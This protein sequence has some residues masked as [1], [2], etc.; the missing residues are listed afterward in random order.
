MFKNFQKTDIVAVAH[1]FIKMSP[2]T[3]HLYIK[4]KFFP[5]STA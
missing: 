2:I 5:C 4:F 3:K 1:F